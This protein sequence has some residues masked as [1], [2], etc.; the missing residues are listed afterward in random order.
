MEPKIKTPKIPKTP[1][2]AAVT[3]DDAIPVGKGAG[4]T[5]GLEIRRLADKFVLIDNSTDGRFADD[6][7]TW[8]GTVAGLNGSP[9]KKTKDAKK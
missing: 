8:N 2:K 7:A 6:V 3:L 9:T 1:K 4:M 5:A